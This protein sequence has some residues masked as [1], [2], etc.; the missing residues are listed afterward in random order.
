MISDATTVTMPALPNSIRNITTRRRTGCV[1]MFSA[2]EVVKPTPESAERAW[3]R[4]VSRES[5]VTI[6]ATVAK[7]VTI[8]ET[9]TT[10]K[11]DVTAITS[12]TGEGVAL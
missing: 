4:A 11:T 2:S 5:P 9:T 7:R 3:K 12:G 1:S 8:S 6:S 10:M